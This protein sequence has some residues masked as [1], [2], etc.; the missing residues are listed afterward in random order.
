MICRQ[1]IF[2][3]SKDHIIY[4]VFSCE[5]VTNCNLIFKKQRCSIECLNLFELDVVHLSHLF[6]LGGQHGSICQFIAFICELVSI[7][8]EIVLCGGTIVQ[9]LTH[10]IFGTVSIIAFH[11]CHSIVANRICLLQ[12]NCSILNKRKY[13]VAGHLSCC[14][15]RAQDILSIIVGF[16]CAQIPFL[17]IVVHCNIYSSGGICHNIKMHGQIVSEIKLL[18][19]Y[20]RRSCFCGRYVNSTE[21]YQHNY[22]HQQGQNLLFLHF[23][24]SSLS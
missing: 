10:H 1:F 14:Q 16:H 18:R 3:N 13:D 6:I 12:D 22:R 5:I 19:Y 9:H 11:D 15:I 2:A 23:I 20:L 17:G 4:T 21:A 8:T 7:H 24:V